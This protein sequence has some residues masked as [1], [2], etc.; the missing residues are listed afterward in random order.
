[1]N[2][3][4]KVFKLV[5]VT[6]KDFNFPQG[7]LFHPAISVLLKVMVSCYNSKSLTLYVFHG[8]FITNLVRFL[9]NI[10]NGFRQLQNVLSFINTTEPVKVIS[11]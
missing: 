4:A 8:L 2:S 1:M 7:V 6:K 9:K 5:P 3:N 10:K 11:V